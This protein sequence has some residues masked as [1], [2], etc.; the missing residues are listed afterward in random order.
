MRGIIEELAM[1]ALKAKFLDEEILVIDY[2]GKPYVPM[3]QIVENIGLDWRAQR[4]RILRDDVLSE[5]VVIITTPS[6]GG[7]QETICLPL[8]YLNGWLFGVEVKRV[9]QELKQVL[10]RYKKECYEALWDYWTEG[11]ARRDEIRQQREKIEDNE[12]SSQDRG[13]D[14]GRKL[15]QRK[16]EKKSYERGIAKLQQMEL[17]LFCEFEP[18]QN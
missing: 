14:A 9:K 18:L 7:M 10:L 4:K 2:Y 15:Q 8:H 12:R 6:N 13:S 17:A 16:I 11:V 5:G 3:K 1:Q